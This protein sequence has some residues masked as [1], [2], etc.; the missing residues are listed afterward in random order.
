MD[1]GLDNK[2]VVQ[3]IMTI[4]GIMSYVYMTFATTR[5][6]DKEI[7]K[8][9]EDVDRKHDDIKHDLTEIKDSM[10]SMEH[11]FFEFIKNHRG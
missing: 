2:S 4:G 5:Y 10:K 3:L 9:K 1:H 6:V 8:I 11:R 7:A